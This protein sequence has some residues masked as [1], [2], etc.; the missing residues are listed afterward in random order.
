M[1]LMLLAGWLR[2][3]VAQEV[4][5]L[6]VWII[7]AVINV[8]AQEYLVRGYLFTMIKQRHSAWIAIVVTTIVF[9][10]LHGFVGGFIGIMNVT[11]ASLIF[12]LL[13]LYT[14]GLLAP[15]VAHIVWN[16]VGAICFGVVNLGGL[17]PELMRATLSSNQLIG[18][19]D[20]R[21]EGSLITT[22]VSVSL[23]VVVWGIFW[24]RKHMGRNN[25]ANLSG[26][27]P[28]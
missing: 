22:I 12:S 20:L 11:L 18:G 24:Y 7:A 23:I 2:L 21:I 28:S 9:V 15:I 16:V 8:I 17:Y 14:G 27:E 26:G 1:V 5:L 3:E 6:S 10:A 19:G 25:S 13:L 4:S